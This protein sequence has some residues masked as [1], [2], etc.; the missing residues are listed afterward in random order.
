MLIRKIVK[1]AGCEQP[2]INKKRLEE[3]FIDTFFF[4]ILNQARGTYDMRGPNSTFVPMIDEELYV[5]VQEMGR[6]HA[7]R[8]TRD[9]AAPLRHKIFCD[10]CCSK[11]PLQVPPRP[12]K[13]R[14][15][16][17]FCYF[18]C[19]TPNCPRKRKGIPEKEIWNSLLQILRDKFENLPDEA[20]DK[21]LEEVSK[22]TGPTMVNMRNELNSLRAINNVKKKE[23]RELTFALAHAKV[24]EAIR[25]G[26]SDFNER[27]LRLIRIKIRLNDLKHN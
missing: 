17:T 9:D 27:S 14:K 10:V 8:T 16:D 19:G 4:D 23:R 15:E 13:V 7:T 20:C 6:K 24:P 11:T 2:T 25:E 3:K 12:P 18:R 5:K 22:Y 21:Y 26:N 1:K